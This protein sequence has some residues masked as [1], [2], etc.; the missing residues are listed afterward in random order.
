MISQATLT[1]TVERTIRGLL[2]K[3]SA[4]TRPVEPPLGSPVSPCDDLRLRIA[5]RAYEL[6][7]HRSPQHGRDLDDWLQ[8]EREILSQA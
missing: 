1:E 2:K 8:A 4:P 6:F 3:G 5:Q 7:E